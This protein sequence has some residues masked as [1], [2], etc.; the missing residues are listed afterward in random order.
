MNTKKYTMEQ[1]NT[2]I[3]AASGIGHTFSKE[4]NFRIHVVVMAFVIVLGV[5]LQISAME[6]LFVAGCSMMVLSMELMNTAIENVCNL[7]SAEFHPLIKIIKDVA[8][9]AVLVSAIGSIVTGSVIF[10]PKIVHALKY[11]LC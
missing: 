9:A 2:F 4:V 1:K 6:W 10:L 5:V 3:H 8:A 11:L 7:I